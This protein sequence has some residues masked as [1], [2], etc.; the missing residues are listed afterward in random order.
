MPFSAEAGEGCSLQSC[1]TTSFTWT[2]FNVS[3]KPLLTQCQFC[4]RWQARGSC[5][6]GFLGVIGASSMRSLEACHFLSRLALVVLRDGHGQKS[7]MKQRQYHAGY[8]TSVMQWW[9]SDAGW[10]GIC[11][12]WNIVFVYMATLVAFIRLLSN[13]HLREY[14]PF[15]YLKILFFQKGHGDL[16]VHGEMVWCKEVK[17]RVCI[18]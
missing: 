1:F 12:Q 6:L 7:G 8:L 14:Q 5:S 15:N 16:K 2:F 4:T 11:R 18:Q 3:L 17:T 9:T 10:K 13:E